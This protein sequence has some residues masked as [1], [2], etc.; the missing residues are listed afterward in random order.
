MCE[1]VVVVVVVVLGLAVWRVFE[2]LTNELVKVVEIFVKCGGELVGMET[3]EG[4]GDAVF[5]ED[6]ALGFFTSAL[7]FFTGAFG[8]VVVAVH[9]ADPPLPLAAIGLVPVVPVVSALFL[10]ERDF[11]LLLLNRMLL[12]LLLLLL[13]LLILNRMLLPLELQLWLYH[14]ARRDADVGELGRT[15][16]TV[17]ILL[18]LLIRY[19]R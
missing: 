3:K 4:E 19:D 1:R 12:L 8:V 14:H 16:N 18:L 7:G 5:V 13:V 11:V 10:V 2:S 6:N 15:L 17:I 9:K